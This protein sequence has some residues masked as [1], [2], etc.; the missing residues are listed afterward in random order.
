MKKSVPLAG[1]PRHWSLPKILLVMKLV[2]ILIMVTALQAQAFN[3]TGQSINVDAQQTEIRKILNDIERQTDFRFLYNYDLKALRKKID[4]RVNNVSIKDVLDKVLDGN[5]LNY[6]MLNNNLIVV[7]SEN[8]EENREIRVT[9]RITGDN[10]EP[11]SGVSIQEKGT[12]NG[13]TTDNSGNYS[14][15]VGNSATLVISYIGYEGREVAVGGQSVINVKLAPAIKQIDQV[16]VVG[17]GSQRKRDLTGSVSVVTAA[18]IANRPIVNTGE[19]LQGKAA[20]VQVTSVSGKPGAGLS[21]RIR[22]SSSIS[23]GNEPLYVVDG[24]PMTDISTFS[25]NDIESISILKDAASASIYG[26]RAANGVVVITTKRGKAGKSRI[27][28]NT[29]YGTSSPTNNLDVLDAAQYKDYLED[30]Y[31]SQ[32]TPQPVPISDAVLNANNINWPDEIFRTGNQKSYQ[33]ALSGG[34][35]KTQHY[36]SLGYMDQVGM[37]RPAT[38]D[39]INAKLNLTSKLNNWLSITTANTVSRTNTRDVT[40]NS[41]AARGGVVLSALTTASFI[42]KYEANGTIGLNPLTGWENPLGPIEGSTNKFRQ[43]RIVSNI[44]ADIRF[45][46]GFLFQ[47]RFGIDYKNN[48]NHYFIDPWLTDNARQTHKGT[49]SQQTS[50]DM[51]WL[52]EQTLSYSKSFSQHNFYALA[53]WSV[54]ESRY[55][56]TNISGTDLDTVY[57]REPWEEMFL[58]TKIKTDPTKTVDEWGLVSYFGRI[59]YNFA[60]RYLFQANLRVDKSSKFA[61]E[62]RTAV[63]PSFSAGWRISDEQFMSNVSVV[64]DLKL[65]AGWGRNGNQ[66]GIGSYEYLSLSNINPAGGGTSISTIAPDDLRWE[67]TTQTNIGVDASFLD[68]RITFSA[69]FY[70]KKTKDVLV[71]IPVSG[72]PVSS[73]LMNRGAMKNVGQEFVISSKNIVRKDFTWTTD[74]NISFN[75]NEVTSIGGDLTF[76]S[77][78]GEIY[79]RGYSIV[80]AQGYGLGQ[81]YGY[82]AAG[83]DPATGQQ[84]YLTKDKRA[85]PLPETTPSDRVF[86]GSAQPDF[87]YGMTNSVTYKNFDLTVFL[88]GSQGNK[89][90]NGVRVETEG[91]KDSRNQSTA[92]LDRWRQAGDVTDIPGVSIANNDNTVVSSRFIEDGSYLRFKTITLAYRISPKLLQKIGINDASIYVSGQNLIT[93]T[94]YTGFDPEVSSYGGVSNN[95]DNRNISLGVDYGAYPQAKV[96]LFGIN[97]GL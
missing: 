75:K 52:S 41:G 28:F 9:G 90:F 95:S 6:K 87:V 84:L 11:L 4:I 33:I 5:G 40:D 48:T 29:Y 57:R 3:A 81:F 63:F 20:G 24:I 78:F 25:P 21:I 54:Q 22:G 10:D 82:M 37:I 97:I 30:L 49:V 79:E 39:R 58:R 61:P 50:T 88:Q 51:A 26:T 12:S 86:I 96:F 71:R 32:P 1:R 53:G 15:T 64:Q 35:D 19:A 14:L 85:V 83:V 2:I 43:D 42:P 65:R 89:I 70:I 31:S 74:F 44:G 34:S 62:N 55:D 17:Y 72:Q 16:V 23:A 77:G 45:L 67:T 73:V 59:N 56:Q 27:E 13:T 94:K 38:F 47:S 18:D 7:L 91:M 80:L 66:E 76:L 60:G 46:P 69:D 36:V 92:I 68:R 93:F 8:E